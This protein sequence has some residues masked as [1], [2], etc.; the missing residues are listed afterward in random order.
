MIMIPGLRRQVADCLIRSVPS[1]LRSTCETRTAA[2]SGPLTV[3]V[4]S[5]ANTCSTHLSQLLFFAVVI[6]LS[7]TSVIKNTSSPPIDVP[8]V[9]E[10]Y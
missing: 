8:Y 10:A 4:R 9:V 1:A 5:A 3:I 6:T 7:I 2:L